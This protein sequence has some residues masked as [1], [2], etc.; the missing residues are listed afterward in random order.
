MPISIDLVFPPGLDERITVLRAGDEV[1][2]VFVRTERFGVLIDTLSTPS[3]CREALRRLGVDPERQ[4]LVVVNSHMDWDH[5]WGN[6]AIAGKAPILAH[7]K[8]FRRF[9]APETSATLRD[10][11]GEENRFGEVEL[12][13]P[14]I[15][16]D[17]AMVLHGGDLTL[18][19]LH[20]PGHTPD[21]V[22]VWIPELR[23]C[24]AVDAV[25]YPIPEVWSEAPEDLADL[26]ASLDRLRRLDARFLL[27]AHGRTH[28]PE[29]VQ[30][31]IDYFDELAARVAA[32]P[33]TRLAADDPALLP[34]LAFEDLVPDFTSAE[35]AVLAFYR[36]CHASNRRA[37]IRTRLDSLR[38]GE[39]TGA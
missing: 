8:A 21:H 38:D 5:F 11:R 39:K 30:R 36:R 6:A 32:M 29:L 27:P 24:L 26:R 23:T 13:S 15:G 4:P 10:K 22:A 17:G 35:T 16:F 28:A 25:E 31:N 2:A 20:T 7:A 34:G 3:L 33:D 12:V 9:A 1:D 18:E 19:L 14:T 37:T